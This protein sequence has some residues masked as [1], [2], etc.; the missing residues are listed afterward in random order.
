M[1]TTRCCLSWP[2]KRPPSQRS[3]EDAPLT[4]R[5]HWIRLGSRGTYR[6]P[7]IYAELRDEG[8]RVSHKR[9]ARLIKA[10]GLQGVSRRKHAR[11]TVRQ[12]GAHP[13]PDLVDRDFSADGPNEFWVANITYFSTWAGFLYMAVVMDTRSR[14]VVGWCMANNLLTELVLDAL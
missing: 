9:V 14:R 13:A 6:A 8:I 10:A 3:R 11:T 2:G 12:A 1:G 5:I 7:R 4:N